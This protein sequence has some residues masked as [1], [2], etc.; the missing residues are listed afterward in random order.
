MPW[1]AR[2]ELRLFAAPTRTRLLPGRVFATRQA[3]WNLGSKQPETGELAPNLL[4]ARI[5]VLTPRSRRDRRCASGRSLLQN[6]HT[7]LPRR[8]QRGYRSTRALLLEAS[9]RSN[10]TP[11]LVVRFQG[12]A[13]P[14]PDWSTLMRE[15]YTKNLH[16]LLPPPIQRPGA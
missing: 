6:E 4:H 5:D 10:V 13:A 15:T 11:P 2:R 1:Q 7:E 16:D 12:L 8:I 9:R 14:A 3:P